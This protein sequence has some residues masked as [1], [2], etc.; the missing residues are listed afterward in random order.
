M[1]SQMTFDLTP[2]AT[3]LPALESGPT[4]FA[5]R[6]GT[7]TVLCGLVAAHASLSPRQAKRLG[8]M[9]SGT[10][11]QRGSI[12]SNTQSPTMYRSLENRLRA[13]TDLLGST[14]FKLTWKTR[15]TPSGRSISALRASARPISAS[16]FTS[17]PS[18]HANSVTG[19]GCQGRDGGLNIQTA[20]QLAGWHSPK[21]SDH[22]SESIAAK[23]SRN[24]RLVAAGKTNGCGSPPLPMQ[25]QLTSWA[26]PRAEDA[27][28]AG[29]RHS[30]GVA[31]TLTAQAVHLAGW[32]TASARDWKDTAGM[33]TEATNPNGSERDRI[34]QLPRK[35]RLASWP[36]PN[37]TP[38]APN[39]S[40]DRGRGQLR[41]RATI[42]SLGEMAK[43]V[44]PARL[45]VIGE[46]LTGSSA[47]MDAGGQL[48]PAH[49]RWLMSCHAQWETS[50]P[51]YGDWLSW[52]A[53]V[54]T[55]SSE[56]SPT[57]SDAS[58]HT[59]MESLPYKQPPSSEHMTE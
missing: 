27:E 17:W 43:S 19:S 7:I 42:Q 30:R 53:F 44:G 3:S 38:D 18:P 36:T 40:K 39:M 6:I 47:G 1:L 33:A 59:E 11:G 56:L 34:D 15:T 10:Y 31:D 52:Q 45:T 16:D 29:M 37:C 8:S 57:V 48:N 46:M 25:V 21:T 5:L 55:H 32:P 14:L 12:S 20:A 24:A 23:L 4:R 26:T 22:S 51:N 50:A 35:A 9:T 13:Q 28:S 49:S 54:K 58:G 41:E 2:S